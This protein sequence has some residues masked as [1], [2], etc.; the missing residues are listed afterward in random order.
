MN[1]HNYRILIGSPIHQKPQILTEF[2]QS[3]LQLNDQKIEFHYYFI[4]DNIDPKSQELLIE[5]QQKKEH[6]RITRSDE[7]KHYECNDTTHYWHSDLVWKVAAFKNSIMQYAI[8]YKFD[9]VFLIDSDLILHPNTVEQLVK[10]DKP[11]VSEIFWTKWVPEAVEQPQVWLYDE[12]TQWEHHPDELHVSEE[13]QVNRF[14]QFTNKM[15]IPGLYEVGGLGACTLIRHDALQAGVSFTRIPNISYWGEDRHFCIRAAA[16]GIPLYVDTHYPALHLYRESDL[17]QYLQ[18]KHQTNVSHT[19]YE[20]P[21]PMENISHIPSSTMSVRERPKLTL[22][23]VIRNEAN[24]YLHQTLS[25]HQKYIDEAVIIDDGSTDNSLE[26]C[27]E[28]LTNI[29]LRL[30]RNEHSKFSNEIQLRQQQWAETIQTKPDWILNLDADEQFES[31]FGDDIN[32][33]L[34]ANSIDCY[35]FR[36]FDLWN[37]THYREDQYWHAHLYYR[38][39]L[40]RYRE[41]F[42]PAWRETPQHCGRFPM[43]VLELRHQLSPLRLKH[44]GWAKHEHR[45]EKYNR[46]LE[47]DPGARYGWKEQYDSIL[48]QKPLLIPW[49]Q[50]QF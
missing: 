14:S 25:E 23:M 24:R 35:C 37:E 39:F 3:L 49:D 1:K 50:S 17:E 29:P 34:K 31:S 4:D 10:A 33:M 48:D 18:S 16:L 38:P 41:D 8:D 22:T 44:F 2:L 46:Y 6:S 40:I 11:I 42:Q 36:L 20:N 45:I 32:D 30:I 47:L 21:P 26:I 13:E 43:N 7:Q 12:Y 28:L 9:Y 15:K 27:K 5:F 19:K